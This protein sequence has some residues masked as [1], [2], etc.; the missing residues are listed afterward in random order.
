MSKEYQNIDDLFKAELGGEISKAPAFVKKNIDQHI[1]SG[2]KRWLLWLIPVCII[3]I[4]LP[5]FISSDSD[6]SET[7][8][9]EIFGHDFL[10]ENH[11]DSQLIESTDHTT[12][13]SNNS[14][15]NDESDYS[16]E[17][18]LINT[19]DQNHLKAN[20]KPEKIVLEDINQYTV[21]TVNKTPTGDNNSL[22]ELKD[23][24]TIV[25]NPNPFVEENK[26]EKTKELKTE[27]PELILNPENVKTDSILVIEEII[28][29]V[30]AIIADNRTENSI[31]VDSTLIVEVD[32]T[33]ESIDTSATAEI[34]KE[35]QKIKNWTIDAQVFG[36]IDLIQSKFS[37]LSPEAVSNFDNNQIKQLS[38]HFGLAGFVNYKNISLGTGA[39]IYKLSDEA[40][41]SFYNYT[42]I[43]L[44]S[45]QTTYFYN[46]IYDSIGVQ[47]DSTLDST[48]TNYN[49]T[50]QDSSAAT[51]QVTNIYKIIS[52][53]LSIGYTFNINSWAIKPRVSGIFEIS[54]QSIV[55]NYPL[56]G[57]GNSG[58]EQLQA[59]KF[60]FSLGLELEVRKYFGQFY[61]MARPGYRMKLTNTAFN[62]SSGIKHNSFNAVIGIGYHFGR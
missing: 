40:E 32:S 44:D 52:I 45:T 36:G 4:G 23:E 56:L 25:Q 8:G 34:I 55:G 48:I 58:L 11:M 21:K 62:G 29:S 42:T 7:A 16:S 28:D 24:K 10:S 46:P 39:S 5:F 17:N 22:K 18:A 19:N 60:G 6:L 14:S 51:S 15:I 9:R 49:Y 27:K 54:R 61:A 3:A 38:S 35:E 33:Q 31:D 50:V 13:E 20:N 2:S 1:Q 47:I 26:N 53:P 57:S 59:V 37:S 30:P 12:N 41:Y 43:P